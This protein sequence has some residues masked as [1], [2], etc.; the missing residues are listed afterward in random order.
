[1]RTNY[2]GHYTNLKLL[3]NGLQ[4]NLTREG[5]SYLKSELD[6]PDPDSKFRVWK[7]DQKLI[8]WRLLEDFIGNGYLEIAL[9]KHYGQLGALTDAPIILWDAQFDDDYNLIDAGR[10][11]WFPEYMTHSELDE[12]LDHWKVVFTEA[13]TVPEPK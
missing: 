6:A 5:R 12:L 2:H 9:E 1:M 10:V 8:L 3:P 13:E 11:F 7:R 4:I